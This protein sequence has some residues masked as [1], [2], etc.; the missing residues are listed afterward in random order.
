MEHLNN[1]IGRFK[2]QLSKPDK[3][4]LGTDKLIKRLVYPFNKYTNLFY[5]LLV[6]ENLTYDQNTTLRDVYFRRNP[7][8]DKFEM[9]PRILVKLGK[10]IG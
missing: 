5:V 3:V 4:L 2:E 8:L 9:V 6:K 1:E 7:N 10:I